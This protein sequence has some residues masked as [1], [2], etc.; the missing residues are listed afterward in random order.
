LAQNVQL[1]VKIGGKVYLASYCSIN[2]RID[3][4][5]NFQV[6]L[7]VDG[8]SESNSIIL[9]QAKD[10]IGKRIEIA[11]KIKKPVESN[12]QNE[13][14]GIITEIC[15]DRRSEGKKDI[16]I[17]GQS[18]TILLDGRPNCRSYSEKTLNDL[19]FAIHDQ[20]PQNDKTINCNPVFTDEIP[21]IVQYK[22]SNF[23][24]LNRIADN[25]GEW[26]FYDGKE[27]NFGRI[28]KSN[29]KDL[30]IDK[31]LID[32]DFSLK[33]QNINFK[34]FTYDY[35]KNNVY[36][37]DT[38]SIEVN[39]LDAYGNHAFSRSE[40]VFR[41]KNTYYSPGLFK[42][43]TD[44]KTNNETKKIEKT[45]DLIVATGASDNPYLNVGNVINITGEDTNED[46]F[47]EFIIISLNH[48]IDLTA[49]YMNNF[50]AIPAEVNVPPVNRNVSTPLSEIQPAIVTNNDDGGE[51]LGRV[52]VR[53]FWQENGEETPWIRVLQPYGGDHHGFYFIPE[54]GDEVM[55][56]FEN[57][58]PD[59]PFV[60]GNT[61][62]KDTRPDH[63]YN[64][65]NNIK[66]IRTR[67]GNQIIFIDENG[68]EEIRILNKDDSS[69]TN[70]ISLSLSNNG[71]ITIKSAGELEISAESI[72]IS[73]Q[74]DITIDS[75]QSTKLTANDYTLDANNGIQLKGQQLNIEGTNTSMK[76]QTELNLEGAQTKIEATVLKMEG[77]GQAELK[78]GMVKV[79]G[80][81]TTVIKG[82]LV[83]IN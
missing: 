19:V 34:T 30:G 62:H 14:Y 68:H 52:R 58:N 61:Y 28:N 67:N 8:M 13:F 6:I 23:H 7:P 35:L 59:K 82:G 75:G 74:N 79:E 69:P 25:Y 70:E 44:F 81:G 26:C 18:P 9:N 78:G 36:S 56:G 33:V 76:G 51:K 43:E 54:I 11:F 21:Y 71:K 64:A 31:D 48:S 57:D 77:S 80:S 29:H 41:Q 45:R 66:S 22:E 55:I 65:D 10:F 38:K 4:H 49:N 17:N 50:R 46:N 39:D 3:W 32:F 42:D 2:Q 5:H 83:Q 27:L 53:F 40:Q 16:L 73:A 15:L 63:W 12:V 1:T 24:F 47:G 72:K 60:I 20:I 37:Q